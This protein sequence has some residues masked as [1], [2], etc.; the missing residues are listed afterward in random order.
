MYTQQL[1]EVLD[2][3]NG[4]T[5]KQKEAAQI[6]AIKNKCKFGSQIKECT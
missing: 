5:Q 3:V 6:N 1:D 4:T 2:N